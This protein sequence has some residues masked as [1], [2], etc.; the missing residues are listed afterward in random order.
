[1]SVVLN[2]V[3]V[4]VL[5]SDVQTTFKHETN[6]EHMHAVDFVRYGLHRCLSACLVH[7][8]KRK[9]CCDLA[10]QY[11]LLVIHLFLSLNIQVCYECCKNVTM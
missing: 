5:E 10:T 1:V 7:M 4:V 6:I 3:R 9:V 2:R 11:R 8:Q